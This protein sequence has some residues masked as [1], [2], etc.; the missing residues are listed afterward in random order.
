MNKYIYIGFLFLLLGCQ[1]EGI[2]SFEQEKDC[3]QFHY[4]VEKNEMTYEYNFAEQFIGSGWNVTYLGDSIS[5]DTISLF[6]SLM[7]HAADVDREF[8]LKGVPIVDLDTLPL[9]IV[10][11]YPSDIFKAN[12]LIDT[13]QIVLIRPDKRGRYGLGVTFDLEDGNS[14]FDTGAEELSVYRLMIS[15]RYEKPGQWDMRADYTGEFSEEKY[16]FMV[17]VLQVQ[18]D[19]YND[20][21]TDNQT[22]R[23]ALE[24]F[25]R[26]NPD[27]PKDFTFPVWTKP[28]WWDNNNGAGT[29][30]GEFSEEKKEFV[31]NVIGAG[32]F[33]P[34]APWVRLMPQ[35]K[36][37]YEDY[38]AAHPD[39][40][41]PFPPFPEVPE[42]PEK[43]K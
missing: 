10:E 34:W 35:L 40:P 24:T 21:G 23:D 15:D 37:A 5:R 1:K 6:L 17:T 38:N 41:L 14:I 30:L 16:A 8:K 39:E 43:D 26:E 25:N 13:I 42:E 18:F 29:Y 12:R 4:N 11:F 7:G 19:I 3:I 33:V 9:A 22:L 36:K 32:S 28:T 27:H 20:W 2:V 31:I